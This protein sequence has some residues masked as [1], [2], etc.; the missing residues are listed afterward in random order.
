MVA[1]S[2]EDGEEACSTFA[3]VEK[4]DQVETP[5]RVIQTDQPGSSG[6]LQMVDHHTLINVLL[7]N[8]YLDSPYYKGRCKAMCV[9]SPGPVGATTMT[10]TTKVVMC[11]VG[12][13]KGSPTEKKLRTET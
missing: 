7:A 9:S 10:M 4:P 6:S 13:S 8:V 11:L 12:C 5:K 3:N 2:N 1:R